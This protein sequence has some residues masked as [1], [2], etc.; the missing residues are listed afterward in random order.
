MKFIFL[1][2]L[3]YLPRS[4]GVECQW[5]QTKVKVHQVE[6]HQ[7]SGH[8]VSSHTRKEH[9]REK[10][11]G[12]DTYVLRFKNSPINGWQFKEIFK[13]WKKDEIQIL[14]EILPTLPEWTENEK[15]IFYRA[16]SS[17]HKDNPATSEVTYGSIVIY[18]QFFKERNKNSIL[19]HESGH[20]L[21]K[22]L[23]IHEIEEFAALS[24]WQEEVSKDRKVYILPPKT[25]IKPDSAVNKEEDFTNH[26]ES[27]H[28][29]SIEYKK[30][31]PK[32][33]DFL[34]KRYSR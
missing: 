2:T 34:L 3:L 9:C 20:H 6:D 16:I 22:K 10:W 24:G 29:N 30:N 19:V 1:L 4:Y 15:Y 28:E 13:S 23:S 11:K 12:A 17:I 31:H 14:L 7:R 27:F 26:L 25:L 8:P 21:F 5:W 32:T 33:Y 18:D